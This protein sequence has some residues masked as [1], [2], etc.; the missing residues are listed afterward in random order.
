MSESNGHTTNFQRWR[1][2]TDGLS[3]P[4]SFINF[5]WYYLIGAS[6]QRRIWLPPKHKPVYLNDYITFVSPPGVGK[7]LVITEVAKLLRHHKLSDPYEKQT[8]IKADNLGNVV[9][10]VDRFLVE[11][12]AQ[13]NYSTAEM[14]AKRGTKNAPEK[15]LLLP[16]AADSTTYEALVSSIARA[17]RSK[18]YQEYDE[19]F[20]RILTKTYTHSSISFCLEELSSLFK[21]KVEDVI[22]FLQITYDCGDYTKDTKNSGTDRI[23]RCCVS[24]LSAATP[25]FM[26]KVF[27]DQL[28]DEG[29][30]SRSIFL[31][32]ARDRKLVTF[33]PELNDLQRQYEKD[34]QD[35]IRKLADLYGQIE[36]TKDAQDFI[37]D[38]HRK[39]QVERPNLDDKLKHYYSRKKIHFMKLAGAV[40]FSESLEMKLNVEDCK[41]ALNLL[42]LAERSMHYAL[43]TSARNPYFKL[44]NRMITFLRDYGKRTKNELKAHLWEH[45]ETNDP[46]GSLDKVIDHYKMIGRI[47]EVIEGPSVYYV[48]VKEEG[49]ILTTK[50]LSST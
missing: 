37:E 43:T 10:P 4:D 31:Y 23:Q 39:S 17:L 47:S 2:F 34:I 12:V 21:K 15:P 11:S 25:E 50:E 48:V 5:G 26:Q 38:W 33:I 30:A 49:T 40:H 6:L 41:I 29:F 18:A 22:R 24:M 20:Q 27:K 42:N 28:A 7:G 32:E 3:S 16:M 9:N 8:V 13:S 14:D 45:L 35:H 46:H 36:V 44:G 19:K 1:T